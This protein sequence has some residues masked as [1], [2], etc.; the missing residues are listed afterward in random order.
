MGRRDG[1][2]KLLCEAIVSFGEW[3]WDPFEFEKDSIQDATKRDAEAHV[4]FDPPTGFRIAYPC[5]IYSLSSV[6]TK[7][8]N[9][10]PYLFQR[11]YTV[12]VID[13]NP[14][15]R[16]VDRVLSL[17]RCSFV[18]KYEADRLHHWVFKIFY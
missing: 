3:L 10:L 7:F 13:K 4:Y 16:I 18:R 11:S 5:I 17:P 2:H 9:N 6:D 8:A 14:D 12:T 1:L 15:S